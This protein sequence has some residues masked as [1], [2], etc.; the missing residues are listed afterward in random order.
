MRLFNWVT[1]YFKKQIVVSKAA[2]YLTV[3]FKYHINMH[4]NHKM[5][6]NQCLVFDKDQILF[7]VSEKFPSLDDSII[8]KIIHVTL[9]YLPV[10]V[11]ITDNAIYLNVG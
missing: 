8:N 7:F 6:D 9:Q 3:Y 11:D 2:D 5:Y 1:R 4:T 10:K